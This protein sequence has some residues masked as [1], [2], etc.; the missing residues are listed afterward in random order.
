[1][2]ISPAKTFPVAFLVAL[3]LSVLALV[4]P[5][6][7]AGKVVEC[8]VILDQQTGAA[9]VRTGTC[10]RRFTPMST[11]KV[12]LALMGYD[13]GVLKDA[14]TP[15]WDYD[16]KFDAE[17]RARK[18]VDPTIWQAD[19]ILWYSQELTRKLGTEAFAGYVRKL[20]Y[21]N[22]DTTGIL[23]QGDAL[24]RAWL[25]NSLLIS[26]DEQARLMRRIATRDIPVSRAAMDRTVEIMPAFETEN[27]WKVWGKTGSGSL[28][29]KNGRLD[30]TRPIGWFVGWAE[31]DGRK[32]AFARLRIDNEKASEPSGLAL[33]AIFLKELPSLM[34]GK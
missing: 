4:F 25:S 26:A 8:T 7:S 11:F 13:A 19:S 34:H 22:A 29:K 27:G 3:V 5:A 30:R 15:R 20:D 16:P 2:S 9:I 18:P 28:R 31:R 33:R 10:D 12:P 6:R 17:K 32:I 14:H 21:G 23:G 24:T 1:M